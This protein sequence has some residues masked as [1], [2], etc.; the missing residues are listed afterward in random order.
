M[1]YSRISL[2]LVLLVADLYSVMSS[3]QEEWNPNSVIA[4]LDINS[5]DEFLGEK[6][7]DNNFKILLVE[8]DA[9]FVGAR[10]HLYYI[11]LSNFTVISDLTWESESVAANTCNIR[12]KTDCGNHVRVLVR[13]EENLLYICGTNS[14]QP[15]CRYYEMRDNQFF[16]TQKLD[17]VTGEVKGGEEGGT[18]VCPFDPK[19]NSTVLYSDGKIY[20]ATVADS[21]SRD[22]LI[23]QKFTQKPSAGQT[24]G[25]DFLVR[26]QPRDSKFLNEP[27]FV[28]SFDI[29]DKVFFFFREI[30]IEN[31]NCGKAVFSRVARV[32]KQDRGGPVRA[33]Q[34]TFTSFFK[35]RLNCSIP[36]EF[37]FYF[38]ELQATSDFGQGNYKPT[39]D[40]GDR[41]KMVYGV[42]TTPMN[43]IKGSAVCAYR[44]S[45]ITDVF[46]GRFKGQA[47]F[48]HNWL[49]VGWEETPKIHPEQ[50]T[51]NSREDIPYKSLNFIKGHPLMDE[52]VPSRGGMP[53][54]VFTS[55]KSRFTQIAIDWQVLA[56]DKQYYDVMFVGT[57][58]G[59][60]IKAINKGKG[61]EVESVVIEDIQVLEPGTSVVGL[62]LI[63]DRS[64]RSEPKL[65]V[66]SRH[67]IVSI[68]LHRCAQS[69]T[70][71]SC[72]ALQDPY[73][74][75]SQQLSE[76]IQ[77]ETGI[78]SIST[79]KHES[80]KEEPQVPTTI[81]SPMVI[82]TKCSCP[83][84]H[85]QDLESNKQND[86]SPPFSGEN[87]VDNK[88]D[89]VTDV[90]EK[91]Q[92]AAAKSLPL[93]GTAVEVVVAIVVVAVIVSLVLGFFIG[94]KFHSCRASRDNDNVFYEVSSL[95]RGRN[96]LS[97]GDNPYFHTDHKNITPK[98]VNYVVNM[99]KSGKVNSSVESKPV[100]KSSKVYL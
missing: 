93:E 19:H 33:L 10:N 87:T 90:D 95:Q 23:L 89:E 86:G 94:F 57:D 71:S 14:Y 45:D 51:N 11:S 20:S 64:Q 53:M 60:V 9:A 56:A 96:R 79:G 55:L 99:T 75:W 38:N 18:G 69:T 78:Q 12:G 39:K 24:T 47:T 82:P 42:F 48:A 25:E 84:I 26:T 44:Y 88:E 1:E 81:E 50:C 37:P 13:K 85:T 30:A 34:N 98:Q 43:G 52:A 4:N 58:D 76:C 41:S 61:T 100:T 22:P 7:K 28:S 83:T 49:P 80:C 77:S 15:K 54:L 17:R 46:K 63:S 27:N 35:A 2:V 92:I 73:C 36:G 31:I 16:M 72:V 91:G 67:K 68:P 70:C 5:V 74:A 21:E 29:D 66:V 65:V 6:G 3:W 97:S 59:R 32:C 40:S 62:K 8:G